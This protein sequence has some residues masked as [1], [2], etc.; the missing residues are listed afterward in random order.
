[1]QQHAN[2]ITEGTIW[3][4]LLFFSVPLLIGNLFQQ[5]YN[6]VDSIIVGNYVGRNALAAVGS[7]TVIINMIIGFFM[8]IAAGAGVL[9]SHFYGA[10]D[11]QA[12]HDVVHTS[13]LAMIY[14]GIILTAAGILL[15]PVI[16]HLMGTPQEVQSSS[17]LYLRVFFLGIIALMIYNM[18]AGLL[19]AVGDSKRPLYYLIAAS[20]CNIILDFVFVLF[21]KLGVFGVALGTVFS[22]ILSAALVVTALMRSN[23]CYRLILRDLH[24]HEKHLFSIIKIGLPAGIQQSVISFSNVIVQS[25]INMFGAAAMAG[26]SACTKIDSFVTLPFMSLSLASTTFIGQNIGAKKWDRVKTSARTSFVFSAI[27]TVLLSVL[28]VIFGRRLLAFFTSDTDVIQYGQIMLNCMAPFYILCAFSNVCSGIIRGAGETRVPMLIMV[29]N[30]CVLRI[31][32]V[33]IITALIHNIV[34]VFSG[35][36]FTWTTAAVMMALY[37]KKGNWL[38]RYHS[39]R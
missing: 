3:K 12:V 20:V 13:M 34:A 2:T 24:I 16:I 25:K 38:S 5:L 9:I 17:I 32:W 15:T 27:I 39:D 4:Q 19:R 11:K 26:Y 1:M 10:K 28:I 31:I 22:E 18:G 23:D 14:S 6:T 35:Y 8:G 7:S 37:Y 21:F 36:L 30:Y 33:S 29:G